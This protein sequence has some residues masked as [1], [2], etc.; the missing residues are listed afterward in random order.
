MKRS[1]QIL[2]G[3]AVVVAA[4]IGLVWQSLNGGVPGGSGQD[5]AARIVAAYE[6]QQSDLWVESSG[7]IER[8]LPDDNE[9]SRHQRFIVR[10]SNGHSVLIAHNIDLAPKVPLSKGDQ[11][12][13]KGE[14]E[15]NNKGGVVHWTHHDP[16][17]RKDG[18]WI[19][20]NGEIYQ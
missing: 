9:G 15:Y 18:G 7:T 16:R 17:G 2:R 12:L 5:D 20:L 8:T 6:A 13:F 4:I 10:L 1:K 14:Y 3:I 11:I 19:A